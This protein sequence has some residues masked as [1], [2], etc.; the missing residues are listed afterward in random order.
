ME[1]SKET[2]GY[3]NNIS[4]FLLG[5]LLLIFPVFIINQTTEPFTLPKQAILIG[6][7]L[8]IIFLLGIKTL[9]EKKVTLRRTPFDLPL[10]IIAVVFL[11]SSLLSVNRIDATIAFIPFLF[12]IIS[13]F[14][15]TNV[16]KDKNSITFIKSCL[17]GGGAIVA[18]I[19]ILN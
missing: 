1:D 15:I 3:L 6:L 11:I 10:L 13:Y 12:A 8:L 4:L 2:I 7:S 17:V 5:I 14:L 18:I 16:T 19:A 9:V